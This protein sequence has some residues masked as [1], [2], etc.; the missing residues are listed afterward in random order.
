MIKSF[1]PNSKVKPIAGWILLAAVLLYGWVWVDNNFYLR[2]MMV[3][4]VFIIAVLPFDLLVGYMGYLAMGQAAFFGTGAYIVGNLTVLRFEYDYWLAL[5]VA[6]TCIG[7][8]AFLLSYP[9]F[10]LRG[11]HF[12][13]G[14]LAMGQLS[15]LVFDSWDWFTGDMVKRNMPGIHWRAIWNE[16]Y[17]ETEHWRSS[18]NHKFQF[19]SFGGVFRFPVG[20]YLLGYRPGFNRTGPECY[21]TG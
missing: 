14:T 5:P 6:L 2:L 9:L 20:S 21:P 17:S 8:A 10:R 7:L 15:Y 4:G 1:W 13:I 16:R 3:A 12:S 18:I 11:V 19:L